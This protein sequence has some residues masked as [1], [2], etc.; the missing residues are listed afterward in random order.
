MGIK[1]FG[2]LWIFALGFTF[3]VGAQNSDIHFIE[4]KN[5]W[6]ASV[7]FA[8]NV[9][10]GMIFF[11]KDKLTY[12]FHDTKKI[13]AKHRE[14]HGKPA[15]M[16]RVFK[17]ADDDILQRH[18]IELAFEGAEKGQGF[19][20]IEE[21]MAAT[22]Y[23]YYLGS[24]PAK[25]GQG[26]RAF[27]EIVRR[28]IYKGIDLRY[29]SENGLLKYDFIVKPGADPSLIKLRINH[30]DGIE[31]DENRLLVK[32]SVNEI[33]EETPYTYQV[34]DREQVEIPCRFKMDGDRISFEVGEEF[35]REKPL[36]IDPILIFSSFSGA[37]VDNW[38][39]TAAY[40]DQGNLYSGG[41]I[42]G[43]GFPNA[44]GGFPTTFSGYW[45]VGIMKVDSSGQNL[46]YRTYFGGK[47]ME[48]PH[49]LVVN[50]KNELVI[51]GTTSSDSIPTF[52][53]SYKRVFRG[54]D[55]TAPLNLAYTNGV[56][57]FIT[58]LDPNG[59]PIA[60][61]Y[62]GGT[63]NDGL[64][65]TSFPLVKNY[66]DE[67]RG[68]VIIDDED[69]IYIACSTQSPD[70]FDN[71][72]PAESFQPVYQG[73]VSDGVVL[74]MDSDLTTMIWGGFVGGSGNDA[75]LSI[76][77]DSIN[78]VYIGGGTTSTNP[79][80]VLF[81]TTPGAL[82]ETPRG[83]P[84]NAD[85]YVLVIDKDGSQILRSTLLGTNAY[86]QVFFIDLDLDENIYIF[87][88]TNGIYP[89]TAG[90]YDNSG[91]GQF[92]VGQF[93]HK[94][95]NALDSTWFS[96]A[97]GVPNGRSDISPTAF[98]VND[99]NNLY[100][101]GW[102]GITNSNS[103]YGNGTTTGLPTTAD[104]FKRTTDGRDFYFMVLPDDG[105]ELLYATFFG[106]NQ[107]GTTPGEHVDGGTSRFDKSGIIYQA[108]CAGCGMGQSTNYPTTPGVF[109]P[110]NNST[111][112]NNAVLKFDLATLRA[113]IR[114]NSVDFDQPGLDQVCFP[115]LIVFENLSIGGERYEWDFGDGNFTVRNDTLPIIYQYLEPG[116]YQVVLRT[117]DENTCVGIDVAT[118]TVRVF[119]INISVSDDQNIC[120]GASANLQAS[121]GVT[122][123]WTSSDTLFL[124]ST[125]PGL[126]VSPITA[127]WYQVVVTNANGCKA[128]DTVN[129]SVVPGVNVDFKLRKI[130]DCE[131]LPVLEL[132]NITE[133]E[134]NLEFN[135]SLGDGESSNEDFI[136]Y[137]Y[138]VPG[139]YEVTL[140]ANRDFCQY[141]K[142]ESVYIP[143]LK[144]PNVITPGLKDDKNDRFVIDIDLPVSLKIFNRWGR[145]VFEDENY[146]GTWNAEG[147]SAGV[148]FYEAVVFGEATCKGWIHVK[149]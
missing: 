142:S 113:R 149:K 88:Q 148:Y 109:G 11:H 14:M 115:D 133:R 129:V 132:T 69:N 10:G 46:L 72:P 37:T 35:D 42:N 20:A 140:T 23:N 130:Y 126:Q 44:V 86:D 27:S 70:F 108:I 33:M 90:V 2:M 9:P 54:G 7:Q 77:L 36:I 40:D 137:T 103:P 110:N 18:V 64:M 79:G 92:V 12:Y 114:T 127:T 68:D 74:K 65:E 21:G 128:I 93:V 4:N 55:F 118:T 32:T 147:E 122:Y 1:G 139:T 96:M 83:G 19:Q 84:G 120:E 134:D 48:T 25:W 89:I 102:G 121:G 143:I 131:S 45:D 52:A 22:K 31:V 100:L 47:G 8:V 141:I 59:R 13:V 71:L 116:E 39:N 87:G 112:C 106:G 144:V 78:N 6:P 63:K 125:Q 26:A 61:T 124:G 95:S 98:L 53:N 119:D 145:M 138:E 136:M 81:P 57:I 123:Q 30:A 99:C 80:G 16:G 56:D 15:P 51:L 101:S 3:N 50:S 76:K 67:L 34:Y 29:Y 43:Q 28:E 97:F 111:N 91:G 62:L 24:D 66:G 38:G 135:W 105:S 41:V 94:I 85:G 117:I 5:Q 146:S 73:G 60:S 82:H 107:S 75:S 49:S 17:D 104:A 58:K